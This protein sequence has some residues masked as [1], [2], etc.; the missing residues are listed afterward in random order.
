MDSVKNIR[1][2]SHVTDFINICL[3]CLTVHLRSQQE[4][5]RQMDMWFWNQH[6]FYNI[7]K[8]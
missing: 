8:T 2:V 4:E 7:N 3:Q 5:N 1:Y 6:S